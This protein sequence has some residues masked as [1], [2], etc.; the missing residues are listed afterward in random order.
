MSI[1]IA[2]PGWNDAAWRSRLSQLMPSHEVATLK[3][4]GSIAPPSATR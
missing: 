1:L 3:E 4:P 2:A